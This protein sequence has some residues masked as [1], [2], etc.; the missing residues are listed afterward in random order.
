MRIL[1]ITSHFP[2]A[3]TTEALVTGKLAQ[4]LVKSGNQVTIVTPSFSSEKQLKDTS[5]LWATALGT[6]RR[7]SPSE[8]PSLV[9]LAKLSSKIRFR[10]LSVTWFA[11]KAHAY[12]RQLL[13]KSGFD[14]LLTAAPP[15]PLLAGYYLHKEFDIPWTAIQN[16]PYPPFL[17]PKP[18]KI[19][20]HHPVFKWQRNR[21]A[22]RALSAA[23]AILFPCERLGKYMARSLNLDLDSKM[24]VVP[25]IGYRSSSAAAPDHDQDTLDLLHCGR[26]YSAR[27]THSFFKCFID[28]LGEHPHIDKKIR[29]VLIGHVDEKLTHFIKE[30][31]LESKIAIRSPISY[32]ESLRCCSR[33]AA[34]VLVEATLEEGIFL[35]SKFCDYAMARKPLLLFSPE[36]GT[37]SDLVG[38]Y[39]HPG[40]LGQNEKSVKEGLSRFFARIS[41]NQSL[42]DY[43]Y[44]LPEQFEPGNVAG[45]LIK[46]LGIINR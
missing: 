29:M 4:A 27:A 28:T 36:T 13:K 32:E 5:P 17:Y 19:E 2:P 31:H 10:E 44:P 43:L 22:K 14:H 42:D 21:W 34:L 16:D 20:P 46:K 24:A 40:F 1:I 41:N 7:L 25:H 39:K 38:G 6:V 45:Q 30:R 12:C 23:D 35:P 26:L 9:Q 3:L 11:G 18:Y 37:V 15:D 8:R 33:A